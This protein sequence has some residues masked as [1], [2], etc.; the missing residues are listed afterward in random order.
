VIMIDTGMA[1]VYGAHRAVL[2]IGKD[3]TFAA[4]YPDGRQPIEGKA[5]ASATPLRHVPAAGGRK[6]AAF[7]LA[8]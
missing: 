7:A 2:E 1:D 5:A 6:T 8:R 3:G 4:L